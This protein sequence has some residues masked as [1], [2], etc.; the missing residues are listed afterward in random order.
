LIIILIDYKH[1]APTEEISAIMYLIPDGALGRRFVSRIC[2]F[3]AGTGR[4]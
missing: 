4:A 1:D 2:D 3:E